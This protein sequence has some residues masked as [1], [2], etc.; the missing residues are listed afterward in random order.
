MKKAVLLAAIVGSVFSLSSCCRI[1]DCCFED[2]CAPSSYN[3]C[4]ALKKKDKSSGSSSACGSY[5]PSCSN[6]CSG[7][8]NQNPVQGPQAKGCTPSDGR[9]R[10]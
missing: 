1:V 8:N 4:E 3:P 2:P 7:E 5:L 6:P 10:Q 9:C